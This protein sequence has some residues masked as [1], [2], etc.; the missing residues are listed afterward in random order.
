MG[1]DSMAR[2][3]RANR[4]SVGNAE[5]AAGVETPRVAGTSLRPIL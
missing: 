3:I 2:L 4:D 5:F 1:P